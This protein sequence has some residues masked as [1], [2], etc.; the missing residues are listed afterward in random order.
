MDTGAR[1]ARAWAQAAWNQEMVGAAAA[2]SSRVFH[3]H[4]QQL[5][6][7]GKSGTGDDRREMGIWHREVGIFLKLPIGSDF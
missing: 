3:M 5:T 7:I 4:K 6:L 2:L 1:C